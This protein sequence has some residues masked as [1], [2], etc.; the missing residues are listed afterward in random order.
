MFLEIKEGK[1]SFI[2]GHFDLFMRNFMKKW[3]EEK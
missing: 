3:K 2:N 1:L